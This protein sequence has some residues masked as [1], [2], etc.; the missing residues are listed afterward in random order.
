MSIH[1]KGSFAL[2]WTWRRYCLCYN[3]K[4]RFCVLWVYFFKYICND[5]FW[6]FITVGAPQYVLLATT[7]SKDVT[8]T[9]LSLLE[10]FLVALMKSL[11]PW[12][13]SSYSSSIMSPFS[14]STC[15]RWGS[16]D[17]TQWAVTDTTLDMKHVD[18]AWNWNPVTVCGFLRSVWAWPAEAALELRG[19]KQHHCSVNYSVQVDSKHFCSHLD[20]QFND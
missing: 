18:T 7:D 9:F 11:R 8:L 19:I 16:E 6:H 14:T 5:F 2:H 15:G 12:R 4:R 1:I 13:Y 17:D 20:K 10:S 3:T